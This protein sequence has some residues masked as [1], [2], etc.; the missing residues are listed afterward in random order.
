MLLQPDGVE[1]M[2]AILCEDD[3]YFVYSTAEGE[4]GKELIPGGRNIK[5]SLLGPVVESTDWY[6][7]VDEQNKHHYVSLLSETYL[8]GETRDEISNFLH[9]FWDL[10]PLEAMQESGIDERDLSLLLSGIPE[11]SVSE[12]RSHA[13]ISDGPES[14]VVDWFWQVLEDLPMEVPDP[15]PN[16]RNCLL[17]PFAVIPGELY[18]GTS[19]CW[20]ILYATLTISVDISSI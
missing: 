11:I 8:C 18:S 2:K 6:S 15:N 14:Q 17:P 12:W 9:G 5:V 13:D 19:C 16:P 3:I 7:Q 10:L 20:Y 1:T 4:D